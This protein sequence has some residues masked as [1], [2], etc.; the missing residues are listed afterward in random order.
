VIEEMMRGRLQV[1][2]QAE[3]GQARVSLSDAYNLFE[4]AILILASSGFEIANG[5]RLG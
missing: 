3:A 4:P 2:R 1:I 5:R